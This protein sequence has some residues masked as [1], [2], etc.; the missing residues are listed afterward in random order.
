M[1]DLAVEHFRFLFKRPLVWM[2]GN[3]LVSSILEL[4]FLK[5]TRYIPWAKMS[6]TTQWT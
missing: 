2:Y 6:K 5:M 3:R 4:D 1:N